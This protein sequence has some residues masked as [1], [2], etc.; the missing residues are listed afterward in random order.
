MLFLKAGFRGN[1]HPKM[2]RATA[3]NMFALCNCCGEE[4][5]RI[6]IDT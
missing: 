1:D 5:H 4:V 6:V 3:S 2:V